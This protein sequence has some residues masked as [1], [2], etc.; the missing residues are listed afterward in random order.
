MKKNLVRI[1]WVSVLLAIFAAGGTASAA[2][3]YPAK[4]IE[5][6]VG[7]KPG[8]GYSD[9][10]QTLAPFIEKHL[11]NKVN[12]VVR[13]MDGA[14]NVVAANYLQKAKPD[15]YTIG[16]Y[17][18]VGL[19]ATQLARKVGYDLN[20]VTWLARVSV[21][22]G[23][24]LVNAKGPYNSILDFKKQDKPQYIVSIRGFSD[25]YTLSAAL[26]FEKLG[27]K[28]KP[29]NH[30]GA[31]SAILAVIRG[32]ADI[33]WASYESMQQYIDNGDVKAVLYYGNA[34]SP[35]LPN[36]P[37]VAEAGMPDL[38]ESMNAQRML[39]APPGLP[40]D[41]RAVLEQAIKQA[42]EDPE[43]REVL[44]KMKK[45]V[46]YLNGKDAEKIVN[47]TLKSYSSYS[48]VVKELM[49]TGK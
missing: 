36:T 43:F 2:G 48:G 22:N 12:V 37:T 16:I 6:V 10:A 20:K 11:P 9:W 4:N 17:N 38:S 25:I 21:D 30:E 24:A 1:T 46:E 8:G 49:N 18:M 45:T 5:F 39:G 14:G 15:G 32:D 27:V 28:W 29:L 40:A 41:V 47:D 26:T 7:Y 35:K 42:V 3:K 44:K 33:F 34:R 31:A 13:N 23:V 19:A